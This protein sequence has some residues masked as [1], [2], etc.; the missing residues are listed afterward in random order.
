MRKTTIEGLRKL[1]L[2]AAAV[3]LPLT[4]GAA[5]NP[6][7]TLEKANLENGKNIYFNGKGD[8]PACA[9]CHGQEGLGDD[10]MGTPR[11]AGQSF[12]YI[13]KQ[14]HDYASD[15]RMDTTMFVMNANAKGMSEQ[16]IIDVSAFLYRWEQPYTGSDLKAVEEL[17]HPVGKRYLGKALVLYGAPERGITSCYA[18]HQYN[19]RGAYP[20]YPQLTGQTYVYLVNQLKQWRDG[21]RTNDLMGQMRAVARNMSDEDIYNVAAF[22]T[23]APLTTMGNSFVPEQEIP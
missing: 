18:C 9:S 19:G 22:L 13:R 14:L 3:M 6:E 16:D 10:A 23:N 21:S 1:A 12:T 20:I 2:A 5:L 7:E 8:V 15:K 4:A 17:G 11:L